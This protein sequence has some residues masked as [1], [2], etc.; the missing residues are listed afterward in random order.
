VILEPILLPNVL[1]RGQVLEYKARV[2]AEWRGIMAAARTAAGRERL[3]EEEERGDA[4]M[5]AR[6]RVSRGMEV[7]EEKA[8]A[9][10]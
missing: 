8:L 5:D 10:A 9:V 3:A 7:A 6:R 2:T 4:E 1:I